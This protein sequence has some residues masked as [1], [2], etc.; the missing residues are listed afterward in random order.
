MSIDKFLIK[1]DQTKILPYKAD[2]NMDQGIFH[3]LKSA[4]IGSYR[5]D[6]KNDIIYLSEIIYE[7]CGMPK[8][9]KG[10]LFELLQIVFDKQSM[11]K[12]VR[13]MMEMHEKSSNDYIDVDIFSEYLKETRYI[14]ISFDYY[15]GGGEIVGTVQDIHELKQ[16]KE[17]TLEMNHRLIQIL[18]GMPLPIYYYDHLGHVIF[19]NES[20]EKPY[21]WINP[22]IE[23]HI[24]NQI[25]SIQTCPEIIDYEVVVYDPSHKKYRIVLDVKDRE[26]VL[27]IHRIPI[28]NNNNLVGIL[29]IH[30]DITEN[31]ENETK[32]QKVLKTHEL[33]I[34]I[35]D[36]VD[37]MTDLDTL[38][39]F[40]LSN[41]SSVIPSAKRS[42]ILKIDHEDNFYMAANFGYDKDYEMSL[43][44]PFKDT[45]AY[46]CFEGDYSKSIIINDIQDRFGKDYPDINKNQNGFMMASNMAAPI[47]VAGKLYGLLSIDSD[48]NHIFDSVDLSLIDYIRLQLERSISKHR[49]LSQYRADSISDPL[50]GVYN[51][52]HLMDMFESF[53]LKGQHSQKSFSVVIFDMDNL[54]NVNDAYGHLF[55]DEMLKV[56]SDKIQKGIREFDLFARFGG[57]EFVCLFWDIK[58]DD[59]TFKLQNWQ[60]Q[61]LQEIVSSSQPDLHV[62]FSYGISYYP[63]DGHSFDKLLSV[64]DE[65]MYRQKN[66]KKGL[67]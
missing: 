38:F 58:K 67:E 52:R 54:K 7:V 37:Q 28:K 23:K 17:E 26:K 47:M 43:K 29:Y 40:V 30:E 36:I 34:K 44:M 25:K 49:L 53:I 31:F 41:I 11:F 61:L 13:I 6:M 48:I 33:T 5:W 15:K 8:D 62:E 4:A 27:L 18:G 65:R 46:K 63:E 2:L 50:T 24:H 51:R 22:L 19:T 56:F 64:A 45:F 9:F 32:N 66:K 12:F 60:N 16:A 20:I 55:G 42:C 1:L 10:S 35:K 59:L 39:N 21:E 14:R 57:D 3:A